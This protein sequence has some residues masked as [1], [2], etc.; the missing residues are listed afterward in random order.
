MLLPLFLASL[1]ISAAA[2]FLAWRNNNRL[3]A[4]GLA[5]LNFAALFFYYF[6]VTAKTEGGIGAI[7]LAAAFAAIATIIAFF[8]L[9]LAALR[10]V[11]R[12]K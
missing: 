3:I 4:I 11:N 5:I 7:I 1:I 9:Y 12:K 2:I 6:A 10:T 8:S